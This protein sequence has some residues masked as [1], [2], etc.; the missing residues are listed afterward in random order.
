MDNVYIHFTGFNIETIESIF[1]NGIMSKHNLIKNDIIKNAGIGS[2]GKYY[3]SL[4][5]KTDQNKCIYN[6]FVKSNGFIGIKVK[7]NK[8]PIKAKP[9]NTTIFTNTII[10]IRYSPYNDEWQTREIITPNQFIELSYPL[11]YISEVFK[12]NKE[13]LELTIEKINK[14][15]ELME[16]YNIDIPLITEKV[17]TK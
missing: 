3:I 16:I 5:K 8:E 4:T 14:I 6:T 1:R 15:K 12:N 11:D 13:Y 9:Q 7:L 2:N 17:Y 10:P